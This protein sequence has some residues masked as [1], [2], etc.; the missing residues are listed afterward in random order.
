[1]SNTARE[2]LTAAI[3]ELGLTITAEFIPWSKSRSVTK[4]AKFADRNLNWSVT[5]HKDGRTVLTTL[6]SAGVAH[7]P[8]YN[9]QA[10]QTLDYVEAITFETEHGKQAR[11]MASIGRGGFHGKPILPDTASVIHGL[12]L[13]ASAIDHPTFE[14]WASDFGYDSDSRSAERTYRACLEIGLALRAAI[15]D[16]GLQQLRDAAQDY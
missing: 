4:A 16:K 9:S 10:E 14:S 12:L 15:G 2:T 8:S 6:Y 13:D 7:C 11:M 3:Q 1:M 5:L